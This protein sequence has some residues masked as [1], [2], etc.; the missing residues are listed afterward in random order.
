MLIHTAEDQVGDASDTPGPDYTYGWGLINVTAA[1]DVI[2]ADNNPVRT[3]FEEQVDQNGVNQHNVNVAPGTTELRA[4]IVWTDEPGAEAAAVKLVNGLDLHVTNATATFNPWTLDPAN[5]ANPAN[6]ATT[7]IDSINN[8]EQVVIN[9]PAS[10]IYTV[11]VNGTS[12][13]SGPQPYTLIV[14]GTT[15]PQVPAITPLSFLLAL[16]SLLG[17]GGVVMRQMHKR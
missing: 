17:L 3:I 11:S 6:P 15:Y 4:T 1:A 2:R 8:V 14:T 12:V 7:G 13:P 16:V 9:N 10:G 5:P